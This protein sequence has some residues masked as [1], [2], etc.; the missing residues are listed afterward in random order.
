MTPLCLLKIIKIPISKIKI[1][2]PISSSM[3]I[4]FKL[5]FTTI[6][7]TVK[8]VLQLQLKILH[9]APQLYYTLK[10]SAFITYNTI[11]CLGVVTLFVYNYKLLVTVSA[12]TAVFFSREIA[13]T[14]FTVTDYF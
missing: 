3:F 12:D 6:V 4:H 14:R 1:L 9:E 13:E 7:S 8:R 5:Q 2:P 11:Y 10:F